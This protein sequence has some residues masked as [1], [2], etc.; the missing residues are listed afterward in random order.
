[1]KLIIVFL[2]IC[3]ISLITISTHRNPH[4][5]AHHSTT[6]KAPVHHPAVKRVTP[7]TKKVVTKA[8]KTI[9]FGPSADNIEGRLNSLGEKVDKHVALN[10]FPFKITRCD[11]IVLFPV[12][13]INDAD[14][15]RVRKVGYAAITAHYTNLFSDKDGQKLVQQVITA[16]MRGKPSHLL[17]ARGC[18]HVPGGPKQ[19]NM[20][21]CTSSGKN[22]LNIISVYDA[23]ERCSVGDNLKPISPKLLKELM[24]LCGMSKFSV[25]GKGSAAGIARLNRQ[26]EARNKAMAKDALNKELH[27]GGTEAVKKMEEAKK[28]LLKKFMHGKGKK[29]NFFVPSEFNNPWEKDRRS[30]VQFQKLK[31]PG[32]RR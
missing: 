10:T 25:S 6:K 8:V 1:M 28:K 24:K 19:K 22:A 27:R 2:I 29:P 11:Q 3:S 12:H 26:I 17:G 30:Y 31:I 5:T 32:S 9:P 16:T 18:I 21:I 20:N 15:Y 13:F 14:D 23:F 7:N 4:S